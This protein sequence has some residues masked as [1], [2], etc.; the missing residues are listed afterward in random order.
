MITTVTNSTISAVS[1]TA[2]TSSLAVIG[3][4][5]LVGL[6]IQKELFSSSER[7]VSSRIN[8]ALNIALPSMIIAFI[9]IVISKISQV[10]Q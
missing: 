6:L 5:I 9:L 7:K 3:V 2:L 4:I 8:M 10:L 1:L